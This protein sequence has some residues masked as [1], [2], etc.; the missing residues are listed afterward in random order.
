M[1]LETE[2]ARSGPALPMETTEY[3]WRLRLLGSIDIDTRGLIRNTEEIEIAELETI[4]T[5]GL[6]RDAEGTDQDQ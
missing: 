5:R 2:H 3:Q 1:S 6:I 4:D